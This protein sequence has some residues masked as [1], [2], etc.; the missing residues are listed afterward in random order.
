MDLPIEKG[1]FP[2]VM[3]VYQRVNPPFFH[4][5]S[6][7]NFPPSLDAPRQ[8]QR[9]LHG[10]GHLCRGDEGGLESPNSMGI[11]TILRYTHI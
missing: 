1:D 8:W 4:H 2:I 7:M 6:T 10:V 11:Y 5:F 9:E 3:L